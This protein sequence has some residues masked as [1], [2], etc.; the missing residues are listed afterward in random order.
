MKKIRNHRDMQQCIRSNNQYKIRNRRTPHLEIQDPGYLDTPETAAHPRTCA[1]PG[2]KRL[3]IRR[4][5]H[6]EDSPFLY[7][8]LY[9]LYAVSLDCGRRKYYETPR[10]LTFVYF[11]LV[12][13]LST[14]LPGF[15]PR[16]PF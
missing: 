4:I 6:G 8:T 12:P 11:V 14:C 3:N 15:F 2:V 16:Y 9:L 13:G 5:R 1:A 10:G 7:R